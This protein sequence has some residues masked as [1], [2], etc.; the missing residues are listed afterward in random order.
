MREIGIARSPHLA[1]VRLHG[2]D[3][4]AVEQC[5]V[6]AGI[7]AP[8][9]LDELE[10]PH[11]PRLFLFYF[12]LLGGSFELRER[13]QSGLA[14]VTAARLILHARQLGA[15]LG[16]AIS[17]RRSAAFPR[18]AALKRISRPITVSAR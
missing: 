13:S 1:A 14:R 5:L 15:G 7:V 2:I 11:H 3:V 6:A 16:H 8:H 9:P 12:K 18:G 17:S 4:G 10:L